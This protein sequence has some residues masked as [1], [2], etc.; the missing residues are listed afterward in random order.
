MRALRWRPL[1][2]VAIAFIMPLRWIEEWT[3]HDADPARL[4]WLVPVVPVV[5]ALLAGIVGTSW[6]AII[7]TRQ[8]NRAIEAEQLADH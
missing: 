3:Q 2:G 4:W 6:Q 5:G 1:I 7:A 8:R